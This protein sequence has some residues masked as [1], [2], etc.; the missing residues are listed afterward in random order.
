[1]DETRVDYCPDCLDND[2][3]VVMER[4]EWPVEGYVKLACPAC[5]FWR[6]DREEKKD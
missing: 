1:M 5:G 4:H 3:R 2:E 6:L